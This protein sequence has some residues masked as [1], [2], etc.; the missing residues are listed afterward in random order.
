MVVKSNRKKGGNNKKGKT[1]IAKDL[2]WEEAKGQKSSKHGL[3]KLRKSK[4]SVREQLDFALQESQDMYWELQKAYFRLAQ[5][6]E[7]PTSEMVLAIPGM[8]VFL[9]GLDLGFVLNISSP[10]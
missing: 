7:F 10:L 5:L 1:H 8:C 6:E 4:M 3:P 9:W 2:L